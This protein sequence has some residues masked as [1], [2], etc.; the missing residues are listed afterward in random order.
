MQFDR[1][2]EI[3][4]FGRGGRRF[5][6]DRNFRSSECRIWIRGDRLYFV[7]IE[8]PASVYR[9]SG[10]GGD[11]GWEI[12]LDNGFVKLYS[13]DKVAWTTSVS[14]RASD[15]QEDQEEVVNVADLSPLA[16]PLSKH[17]LPY[18]LYM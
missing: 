9:K 13:F 5:I 11:W 10:R 8:Q 2:R 1:T 12:A 17:E 6:D 7:D 4:R 14:W 3:G 15:A 16:N 18:Q